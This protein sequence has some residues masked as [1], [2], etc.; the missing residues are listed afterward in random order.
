MLVSVYFVK[1]TA[2]RYFCMV[3]FI[4]KHEKMRHTLKQ[5]GFFKGKMNPLLFSNN[6]SFELNLIKQSFASLPRDPYA[7]DTNNRFRAYANLILIPWERRLFWMPTENK[8][9]QHFSSYWQGNHNPEYQDKIRRFTA[10][11]SEVKNSALLKN[12][13][14]HDFD[15]TFWEK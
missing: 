13:I 4:M 3:K 1:K 11:N 9:G 12:L 8:N 14:L 10:L 2:W 7:E 6:A 5:S 15:L